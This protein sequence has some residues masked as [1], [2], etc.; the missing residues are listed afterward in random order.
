[1]YNNNYIKKDNSSLVK[2]YIIGGTLNKPY[3]LYMDD[4]N[5]YFIIY[6]KK[7]VYLNKKNTYKNGGCLY[8]KINKNLEVKIN[9]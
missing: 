3:Q 8:L 4:K 1:M 5:K 9:K 7:N 6:N 2:N